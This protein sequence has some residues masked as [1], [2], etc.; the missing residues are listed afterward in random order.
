MRFMKASALV[1]I[2]LATATLAVA[3]EKLTRPGFGDDAGGG[4]QVMPLDPEK[5]LFIFSRTSRGGLQQ[6]VA[7][8]VSDPEQIER[9]RLHLSGLAR[10]V[11]NGHFFLQ[12]PIPKEAVPGVAQLQAAKPGQIRIEYRERPDGAQ[13]SYATDSPRLVRALHRWL[14]AQARGRAPP[15]TKGDGH[16]PHPPQAE[17]LPDAPKN[18]LQ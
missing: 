18:S 6:V 14:D 13:I 2:I 17:V 9:I 11:R 10:N 4:A 15:A 1:S 8:D 3:Q 12:A 7:K 5:T 16:H